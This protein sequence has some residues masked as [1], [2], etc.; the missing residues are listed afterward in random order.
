MVSYQGQGRPLIF[1]PQKKKN[2]CWNACYQTKTYHCSLVLEAMEGPENMTKEDRILITEVFE[3]LKVAHSELASACSVLSRLSRNLK[4]RQLMVVLQASIR[5]LIQIK[6]TSGLME[7]DVPVKQGSCQKDRRKGLS[8]W[9][10]Q[11]QLQN[12]WRT[13]E[14]IALLGYWQWCGHSELWM[15]LAKTPHRGRCSKLIVC[16]QTTSSLHHR[17]KI[18]RQHW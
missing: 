15:F 9:W 4:P 3:S 17:E 1:P 2:K 16:G 12:C 13:K 5:P 10:F 6:V 18:P 11:T 14:S 7:P 8:Y